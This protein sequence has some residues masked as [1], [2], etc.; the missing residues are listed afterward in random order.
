MEVKCLKCGRAMFK[1]VPLD[2]KGHM[3]INV[4]TPFDLEH[5]GKDSYFK[6]PNCSAKNVVIESN[7]PNGLPQ[8]RI[9]H[10]KE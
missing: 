5:D 6:C 3:A 10:F 9:S 1:T 7:S 2:N 8:A 4:N